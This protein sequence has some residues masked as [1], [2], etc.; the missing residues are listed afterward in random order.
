[1][2]KSRLVKMGMI[3]LFT[4]ALVISQLSAF[5]DAIS[6]EAKRCASFELGNGKKG[7]LFLAYHQAEDVVE[8]RISDKMSDE[9][10]KTYDLRDFGVVTPVKNQSPFGTCWGFATISAVETSIL[11][12]SGKTYEE[13]GL[14]LSEHHLAYFARKA[15]TDKNDSQYKEGTY[16]VD[17]T[18]SELTTGGM[19]ATS[20]SVLSS[21]IGPVSE[22]KIPYRGKNSDTTKSFMFFNQFY[23]PEDDWS[24]PEEYRFVQEYQLI[25]ANQF[26][27]P[28]VY[29]DGADDIEEPEE[30]AKYY[31]GTDLSVIDEIKAELKEGL[32]VTIAFSADTSLPGQTPD[33]ETVPCIDETADGK[34]LHFTPDCRTIN[35]AVTIVGWDDTIKSTDFLDHS[36]DEGGDGLPHQ[37]AGDGA[38]IVKNSWGSSK[39]DFPNFGPWGNVTDGKNDGYFY[40]SYYDPTLSYPESFE[41]LPMENEASYIIDQYDYMVADEICGWLADTK[42]LMSNLF[43]AEVDENVESLSC[44]TF[45]PNTK[46]TYQV[47]KLKPNSKS[48]ID[49]T[50]AATVESEYEH[51]G[52]HR[53]FLPESVFVE[54]GSTYAVVVNET[55]DIDGKNYYGLCTEKNINKEGAI[56]CNDDYLKEH[57]ETDVEKEGLPQPYY[58]IGKVNPG[59]SFVYCDELSC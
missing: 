42:L 32:A 41:F 54:K 47:Y 29:K 58:C 13:T 5:A 34:W 8:P 39:N 40:L 22:E 20:T 52:Y 9:Y 23:S 44:Q 6:D 25:E 59:E 18:S 26:K 46:V 16:M 31:L 57:P 28:A 56:Q 21:G 49:G 45:I 2:K 53:V 35:H 30:R 10:P 11:S 36:N 55:V 24:L 38:F 19:F 33:A 37:P 50:L 51:A 7:A 12:S 3:V 4:I 27:S 15:I 1:M 43:T 17:A 48:P 14:D